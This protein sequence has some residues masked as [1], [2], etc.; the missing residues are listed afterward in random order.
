MALV[1]LVS[2][3]PGSRRRLRL[4]S[5]ATLEP[6][7]EI[8]VQSPE[9]VRAAVER[10]RKAQPTWAALS[11]DERARYL[12]R[13]VRVLL[14]RQDEFLDV[15]V[16]E[17]GKPRAEALAVE[18]LAACDA[19]TFYGKRAKRILADRTLPVH[20]MKT[21]KLRLS[22]RP[23]GVAGIITP[24]NFPFILSL[25]PTAQ[26][27]MAG[28][29]VVLKP[30]EVTPFSGRLVE[31]LFSAVGLPEGVFNLVL[32]DGETGAALVEAGVDKISFTGS[33][34]T[35][36]KVGETCGRNL[37]PFT[38]EL[39]GKDPMIVCADADLERATNG[40]VYGAFA[41]A[42]QVCVSTERVY[43]AEEIAD[44]FEQKVIEKTS[45][46]RQGAEGEFEIG[47][48]IFA[49]QLEIVE[50][51]VADA[52]A[53]GAK[54]RTGGRRNPD[55]PG[56]FYEPTVLTGVTHD[57]LI[58]REETF[59]PVLPI[60][61]V[62]SE[63]EA[64]RLAND[65]PYGLN[66]NVWTRDKRKGERLAKAVHSGSAVVNDCMLTYGVTESPFGGVKESGIGQVNG[67]IGLRS[68]CH[69]QSIL[70]D[71]FGGKSEVLWYPYTGRKL[72]LLK[73]VMRLV[74]G[75]PLGKLFS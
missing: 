61:R 7:G 11:F 36:R 32:G 34:R 63:D 74:W 28:N 60:M 48:M 57:M 39:G 4:R 40:A 14:E 56:L 49:N 42:G 46:L 52:V 72:G 66:A 31:E 47:P 13:A 19:L 37:V 9:D 67:E 15:I 2:N 45:E 53:R 26:A 29:T 59:G 44:A 27:L 3:A 8:E 25:N 23:L 69:A 68:F 18:I 5:P 54:V 71:R 58:M 6:I 62:R 17:T 75:T 20:L 70:I 50:K 65:S 22:Y 24:W 10:A 51:H 21:K 12:Q 43:V 41:N 1:E 73:R 16:R 30:S 35:G 38:L 33:V 55:H 64:L